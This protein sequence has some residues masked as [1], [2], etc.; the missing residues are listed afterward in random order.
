MITDARFGQFS[1][2]DFMQ[3]TF[4]VRG[5]TASSPSDP[6]RDMM[7]F[8]P[9][10]ASGSPG[11][12]GGVS[13][14]PQRVTQ[15]NEGNIGGGP[16]GYNPQSN[17]TVYNQMGGPGYSA[18]RDPMGFNQGS[19]AYDDGG[20]IPDGDE[21]PT[22]GLDVIQQALQWGRQKF[23]VLDLF[24]QGMEQNDQS[25][26]SGTDRAFKP[27]PRG[28]PTNDPKALSDAVADEGG[29]GE[30]PDE[31]RAMSLNGAMKDLQPGEE[32]QWGDTT[33]PYKPQTQELAHG[34]DVMNPTLNS[35]EDQSSMGGL[36]YADGGVIP[37]GSQQPQRG[38]PPQAMGYLMGA[39]AVGPEVAMA[40]EQRIDP[41]GQMDPNLRKLQ[42]ISAAGN[43]QAAFGLM[44]HYRQKFNA[45]NAFARA[46]ATGVPGKP[47]DPRAA[48]QAANQAY[49]NVPDGKAY[50]FT[51]TPNGVAVHVSDLL[52]GKEQ[53][54]NTETANN[55]PLADGGVV[56]QF[57]DG[58]PNEELDAPLVPEETPYEGD[59][60]D[61]MPA[62]E[63]TPPAEEDQSWEARRSRLIEGKLRPVGEAIASQ[64]E[65]T[66]TDRWL[67]GKAKK[68]LGTQVYNL[69]LPQFRAWLTKSGQFDET[70]EKGPATLAS[71]QQEV[72]SPAVPAGSPIGGS[73]VQQRD[74][75]LAAM[76]GP[77]RPGSSGSQEGSS[78]PAVPSE[79]MQQADQLFPFLGD[80]RRQQFI[81]QQLAEHAKLQNELKKQETIWGKRSDIV[82][83]QLTNKTN[84]VIL[85]QTGQNQRLDTRGEQR[86]AEARL[87]MEA[88]ARIAH[89]HD[90]RALLNGILAQ[91]PGL[92]QNPQAL[93]A[94][95]APL[96]QTVAPGANP[97]DVVQAHLNPQALAAPQA[98]AAPHAPQQT[99]TPPAGAIAKLKANPGLRADF[100][101]KYG[102]GSAARYLGQ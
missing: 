15:M 43:P 67:A 49:E 30:V 69:T 31:A 59:T 34:G 78:E 101:A 37:D 7:A 44:Q 72:P 25:F 68:A 83:R 93:A 20:V 33:I 47:P 81:Q 89:Q 91:K 2:P 88:A 48:A 94:A 9:G 32:L 26:K 64:F 16:M 21:Q 3:N 39:G 12:G 73:T 61:V 22:T 102:P 60:A 28:K 54:K 50:R 86:M 40:L 8:A 46:A 87:R 29:N 77:A 71:V 96:I 27:I 4:G 45:Y 18:P 51:P 66:E 84:N 74:Q 19:L 65:P 56:K 95:V 38:A 90:V 98:P 41:Q 52:G 6:L 53:S 62:Q 82:D 36:S 17:A 42:A 24:K 79:I 14:S 85:Q 100:D 80:P 70:L 97:L 57:A 55:L 76:R 58:G 75:M 35:M 1:D 10:V 23:N 92:A 11:G 13:T 99:V 5:G 63:G